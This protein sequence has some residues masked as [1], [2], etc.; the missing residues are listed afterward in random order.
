MR[1]SRPVPL[2]AFL[3]S[4]SL[5]RGETV[6]K[7]TELSKF[8]GGGISQDISFLGKKE[9]YQVPTKKLETTWVKGLARGLVFSKIHPGYFF[10]AKTGALHLF[11][12]FFCI[13]LYRMRLM[14]PSIFFKLNF[15]PFVFTSYGIR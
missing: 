10:A 8:A 12:F 11:S 3:R 2:S 15:T 13:R 1:R 5:V 7:G 6:T 14:F 9:A 4:C